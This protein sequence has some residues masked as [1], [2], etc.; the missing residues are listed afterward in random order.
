MI[1][2]PCIHNSKILLRGIGLLQHLR[3][4]KNKYIVLPVLCMA[5]GLVLPIDLLAEGSKDLYPRDVNTSIGYRSYLNSRPTGTDAAP[6]DPYPNP[7]I[8]KVFAKAGETIYMGSSVVGRSYQGSTTGSIILRNPSGTQVAISNSANTTTGLI[9]TR[10]KEL[11]G[12]NRT[13]ITNGYAPLTYLVPADGIYEVQFGSLGTGTNLPS[14][15]FHIRPGQ[16][17]TGT[18][19]GE[20]NQPIDASSSALI[21]A[22]DVSVGNANTGTLFPGR[23][24]TTVFNATAP[25]GLFLN[26]SF[27]GKLY[28]LTP[29]SYI[30]EVNNN[31]QNGASFNFFSNNKGIVRTDNDFSS[32]PAYVSL[33]STAIADLDGRIWDPRKRDDNSNKTNKIFYNKPA[34]A[35]FPATASV[36]YSQVAPT[37]ANTTW[38]KGTPLQPEIKGLVITC[39]GKMRFISNIEGQYQILLDI[40]KDGDYNDDVDRVLSGAT[41]MGENEVVWDGRDG[42]GNIVAT[43]NITVSVRVTTAEVHFPFLDVESNNTGIIISRLNADLSNNATQDVVYWNDNGIS[44]TE[45]TPLPTSVP[46]PPI[47][48]G[49]IRSSVN[50][51]KWHTTITTGEPKDVEFFGNNKTLD[52][53]AF[54]F[55][56]ASATV[57]YSG[58][59]TVSGAIFNDKNANKT[60]DGTGEPNVSGTNVSNGGSVTSGSN[61]YAYLTDASGKVMDRV[62]VTASGTYS[63][64]SVP[65]NTNGLK[66]LFST[67]MVLYGE[68]ITTPVLP[69]GWV[70]TGESVTGNGTTQTSTADGII[71][72]NT[73]TTNITNQN[74]GI[75]Q[76]PV[77]GK[78]VNSTTNPGGTNHVTVPANTFSNGNGTTANPSTDGDGNVTSIRLTTFPTGATSITINNG[79][80]T[81]TYN[82]DNWP[83]GGVIV[84]TNSTGQPTFPISV[85][86]ASNG[87]TSVTIPFVAID[88][89]GA[90]SSN[91]G[92][93]VLNFI[94]SSITGTVFMDNNGT[95]D[96][97]N[98]TPVN[99]TNSGTAPLN[100]VVNLYDA[101]GNLVASTPVLSDGSY[102]FNDVPSNT[103]YQ[104]Q[105]NSAGNVG[106]TISSNPT[107]LPGTFVHVSSSDNVTPGNGI[108][109]IDVAG[110]VTGVN[111]GINEPPTAI[112]TN[113]ASQLNPGGMTS[114]DV[115]SG[116]SGSDPNTGTIVSLKITEFPDKATSITIGG[117]TYTTDGA[118]STTIWPAGGVTVPTGPNGLPTKGNEISVDPIDGGVTVSIPFTVTDNA[119]LISTPTTLDV[120]FIAPVYSISGNILN[121]GN[122]N[123]DETVSTNGTGAL[124][125][126]NGVSFVGGG[127]LYVTLVD[128]LNNPVATTPVKTD[129]TYTFPNIPSGTYS[130]V[131]SAISTGTTSANSPLPGGWNYTG[132]QL[133]TEDG[134]ADGT[135]NGILS[136]VVVG[137]QDLTNANFGINKKPEV[138]P[139]TANSVMNLGGT[140]LSPVSFPTEEGYSGT[141]LE[142]GNSPSLLAGESVT[143]TPGTGGDLYYDYD[144]N[145]ENPPVQITAS[146]VIPNFDPAKV[147]IDP[148]APS[149]STS[150]TF[151]YAIT[152]EAGVTS[153]P[154][155]VSVPFIEAVF[156]VSGTVYTDKDGIKNGADGT[157]FDGTATPIF[158]NL[159]NSIGEFVASVQVSVD[160]IY[161]F[162]GVAAGTDYKVQ[163]SKD[164]ATGSSTYTANAPLP[165]TY[166]NVSS[167]GEATDYTDGV[168]TFSISTRNVSNL[169]FGIQEPPVADPIVN[170]ALGSSDFASTP[171]TGFPTVDGF[172]SIPYSSLLPFTGEDPE[173]GKLDPDTKTVKIGTIQSNTKLYYDY[174]DGGV[175][176]ETGDEIPN[177]DTSKLI[178]YAQTGSGNNGSPFGFN[179]LLHDAAGV[180]SAP[181]TYTFSTSAPLPVTL[182]IFTAK[183]GESNSVTLNWA[184]TEEANSESFE[185]EHSTNG[186][187][188]STVGRRTA[189]GDSKQLNK[190]SYN[191]TTP[192]FGDNLYRLKM[193]DR[194]T[195]RNSANFAY[196]RVVNVNVADGD[197]IIVYPNPATD[198]VGIKTSLSNIA[199]IKIYNS[200]GT[201]VAS[202]GISSEIDVSQ[203]QTG[204]YT[205]SITEKD[206]TLRN[207]KFVIV[208]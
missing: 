207:V 183:K 167:N 158:A 109:I 56:D 64:T 190:Y 139:E 100:L 77:A 33:N 192:V 169:D 186:K 117:K 76:R 11:N 24:Y 28:V 191:H 204:S 59:I 182:I 38:L 198:K 173:D 202:P 25:N 3:N 91:T 81:N 96:N 31:G 4:L 120:E 130:V 140:T 157:V 53:W 104:V 42:K 189:Q 124:T 36:H 1:N 89:A 129:G 84:P 203:L 90:E 135:P 143:L 161:E 22:W 155:T 132:E 99:G 152:D 20:W 107:E 180:F 110:N 118:G 66:V 15:A 134:G 156:T 172:L 206:G 102:T 126:V 177:F 30:Y 98:G 108:N 146:T 95:T 35:D 37:G 78:G 2:Y 94:A 121:D 114:V 8:H 111:F 88:N 29:E 174:G 19:P 52:T 49:G 51:H 16:I 60:D 122:G 144:G 149:G 175:P 71:N 69:T 138:T 82:S 55:D 137:S 54:V 184:T 83:V 47:N 74:F 119:G 58:C 185:I 13:G 148:T 39:G 105:L 160:G 12:P 171:P 153:Q 7:G 43:A 145:G 165:G 61:I 178:F 128:Q 73:G 79:T 41:I 123:S 197:A 163:L 72:L 141:D 170:G 21:L 57:T 40:N 181:A 154:A 136:G 193:I 188:W 34:L 199:G 48:F 164:A 6:F 159:Y 63:L 46:N 44:G 65:V 45:L 196:S 195:D 26:T 125:T 179:Y 80:T 150:A 112:A 194:A 106:E 62:Q 86:P 93:A 27:Y 68:I 17:K 200:N 67:S 101:T 187:N 115:T 133:G 147:F 176:V 103:G 23:V 168:I 97:A 5:L 162:T 10:D 127:A 70:I 201:L 18:A 208:K 131:L 166:G 32:G 151:T 85:D 9:D 142:D 116:F 87:A 50:G 92:T 113:P 205:I 75:Q 14:S